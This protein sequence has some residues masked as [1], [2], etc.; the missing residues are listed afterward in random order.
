MKITIE[1][2]TVSIVYENACVLN[3]LRTLNFWP[4]PFY[5]TSMVIFDEIPDLQV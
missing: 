3:T 4:I 2:G 1:T 5:T